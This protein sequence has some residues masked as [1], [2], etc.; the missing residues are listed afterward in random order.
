MAFGSAKKIKIKT[1]RISSSSIINE[2]KK[3]SLVE[4]FV[5]VKSLKNKISSYIFNNRSDILSIQKKNE[6]ISHYKIF[7]CSKLYSWEIQKIF[8][9]SIDFYS[10]WMDKITS[11]NKFFVQKE[12]KIIRY[13][14]K[15][16]NKAG[17]L[18]A[19]KGDLK[20]ASII[21]K[22]TSLTNLMNW[23][24]FVD[25]VNLDSVLKSLNVEDPSN[26]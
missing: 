12:Y 16:T 2:N 11:N 21:P 5:F 13:K 4:H 25:E 15:V 10:N 8:Q 7:N 14:R 24:I 6:L 9:Q 20:S 22:S 26:N 19:N 18:I 23:L 17:D 3:N 1:K